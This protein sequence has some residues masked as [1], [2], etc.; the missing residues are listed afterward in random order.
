[1]TGHYLIRP[2]QKADLDHLVELMIALQ[3]H[4]E[5]ANP[6][7]WKLKGE[8]RANLKGQL[9]TR[10]EAQ[11]VC[12]LVAEHDRDGIIGAIFGRIVANNRYIPNRAGQVEQAFVREA[13]RRGGV[14]TRLVAELCHFF[15]EQDI[16][17]ISLRYIVGNRE[18]AGFW[19]SLGFSPRII[20]SGARLKTIKAQLI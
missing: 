19:A 8:A 7:L 11:D 16:E 18:A 17:D 14:G 9:A 20:T 12:A 15:S 6:D 10:L 3:D 13:H 1:M 2:A 4:L 5:A